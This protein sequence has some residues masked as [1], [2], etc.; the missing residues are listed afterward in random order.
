MGHEGIDSLPAKPAEQPTVPLKDLF[1]PEFKNS[2]LLL[3]TG[4]FFG[5]LTL[6]TLMSW[7]PTIAKDSGMPFEMATLVGTALN[8]GAALGTASAGMLV[9]RMGLKKSISTFLLIAFGIMVAYGNLK[10]SYALMFGLTFFI[11]FFVQ[12]GFNTFYPIAARIYPTEMR[13]TGVGL[14]MGVGRFGAILGPAIF[15][16]LS[17]QG[18]TNASLFIIFSLPLLV[19]AFCA[20]SIPSKNLN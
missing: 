2:T 19:A 12:G 4:I 9:A 7:V 15:G 1:L 13:S 11:G 18:V 20:Y 3:W 5:F 10:L 14:A 16:L 6:Y 8:F 17:G